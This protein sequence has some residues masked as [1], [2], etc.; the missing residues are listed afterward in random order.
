MIRYP[1]AVAVLRHEV[2]HD[3]KFIDRRVHGYSQIRTSGSESST[4]RNEV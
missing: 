3:D 2:E 1:F 4:R